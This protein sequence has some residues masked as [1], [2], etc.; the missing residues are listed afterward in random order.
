MSLFQHL[1]T[2]T[3]GSFE[4]ANVRVLA[5]WPANA[6]LR[7]TR[8]NIER[9]F[10]R[11][12]QEA[13]PGDEVVILMAGH[14]S[15]QPA[16][17]DPDNYEPDGLD[18]TF[19]PADVGAWDGRVGKVAN[20]IA[21]DDIRAWLR[22][23]RTKGAFVWILF[24]SCH[25]GTMTRDGAERVREVPMS[26]LVPADVLRRRMPKNRGAGSSEASQLHLG[27]GGVVAM[28][29]S[30]ASEVTP[31][32]ILPDGGATW[33]GLFTYYVVE[34]LEQAT[35]PMTYQ[36]LAERVNQ[37]YRS[38]GRF[39]PT[40]GF[41]GSDSERMV[42]GRD[43]LVDRP[44]LL[45]GG[46][47]EHAQWT[48][49]AGALHG[50]T[51]DSVLAVYPP[52]GSR[53]DQPVGYVRVVS[54]DAV[55]AVVQPVAYSDLAPPAP[56]L[57]AAG[58]RCRVVSIAVESKALT[59]GVEAGASTKVGDALRDLAKLTKG[60]ARPEN[61]GGAADWLVREANDGVWLEP[62]AEAFRGA[63]SADV[64]QGQPSLSPRVYLAAPTAGDAD[65]LSTR[66]ARAMVKI[67]RASS[68]RNLATLPANQGAQA[69]RLEASVRALSGV[70]DH[71]GI[72]V[73]FGPDGRVLRV[74]QLVEFLVRNA[75]GR[76]ADVTV[77]FVSSA[78]E[79][80]QVYPAAERQMDSRLEP[81]EEVVIAQTKITDDTLGDEDLVIIGLPPS[82]PPVNLSVLAQPGV[83][84]GSRDASRPEPNSLAAL[85]GSA[86]EGHRGA[87]HELNPAD[88]FSVA[89][90]A[91]RTVPGSN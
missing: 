36:E 70:D 8:A 41:E 58:S 38:L 5:G 90:F 19:L 91:W 42:L 63:P 22:E 82:V 50:L 16:D 33:H 54:V 83:D 85:V 55:T 88:E 40:P 49:R 76:P 44:R 24:D 34:I 30:Q 67:A 27:S 51:P 53:G 32:K 43:T 1:L 14:G 31:E 71:R 86:L 35:E 79:I 69:F 2:S 46:K 20:A 77:F 57:L 10:R 7:P 62:T 75:G 59:V 68:L 47:R 28:Y 73:G 87:S 4:A 61:V 11:L 52:A 74:G 6:A 25:S 56:E 21:D 72:A 37:R 84:H 45:L 89:L 29:A 26:E 66:L 15:Q 12:A 17:P 13:L 48:L 18:E 64:S 80:R 39:G 23:I 9:E 78:F 3:L 65:S 60:A 81:G